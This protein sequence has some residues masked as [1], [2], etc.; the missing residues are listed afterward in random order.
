MKGGEV[1]DFAG[2]VQAGRAPRPRWLTVLPY[3]LV[4]WGLGYLI[5][6][7]T[8]GGLNGPNRVFLVLLAI[9]MVYTPIAV[10]KKWFAL[11]L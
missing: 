3:F 1:Q 5:S 11:P 4:L 7:A 8:D 10:R 2:E 9:W 6:T